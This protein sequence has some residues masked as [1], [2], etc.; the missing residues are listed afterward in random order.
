MTESQF[1]EPKDIQSISIEEAI[2]S[3][4]NNQ[5]LLPELQRKFVWN[6]TQV[7]KLFDSILRGYPMNTFM[8]WEITN[9]KIKDDAKFYKF[10]HH[11][12]KGIDE[13]NE[14]QPTGAFLDHFGAVIDGQQRLTALYIGLCGTYAYKSERAENPDE[15]LPK[16]SL[17]LDL[18]PP[19]AQ[20]KDDEDESEQSE[21]AQNDRV[22]YENDK[23]IFNFRFL[24]ADEISSGRIKG[25][26]FPVSSLLKSEFD[27]DNEQT[28]CEQLQKIGLIDETNEK[29]AVETIQKLWRRVRGEKLI[30]YYLLETQD[31]NDVLG[32]FVRTN[33]GGTRLQGA[34][35]LMSFTSAYWTAG[36]REKIEALT[37]EIRRSTGFKIDRSFILKTCLAVSGFPL[38][39][40]ASN[41]T[42]DKVRTFEKNWDDTEKSVKSGFKLIKNLGF[43]DDTFANKNIAIPIIYHIH[44]RNIADK[45]LK[46]GYYFWEELRE[47]SK[48]IALTYLKRVLSGN[49]ADPNLRRMCEIIETGNETKFPASR[50]MAVV[51]GSTRK[52]NYTIDKNFIEELLYR[53]DGADAYCV[54]QFIYDVDFTE[55]IEQDHMHPKTIFYNG[56]KT[57]PTTLVK[58][59]VPEVD[60]EYALENRHWNSV[61]NL[62]LLKQST[63]RMKLATPLTEWAAAHPNKELF[64]ENG[65][66]LEFKDFKAFIESRKR[67]LT[68]KL[69]EAFGV[70]E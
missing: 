57:R 58:M 59:G 51:Y 42:A 27:T 36:S 50:L 9:P 70:T 43:C 16:R 5:F 30:N 34:D 2:K 3:I 10:I 35:L 52:V 56:T 44:K 21:T 67:V 48:W 62:Q 14:N 68:A 1:N 28:I 69:M 31:L 60:V 32:I 63:N 41:I 33:S 13:I 20:I 11:Y 23:K 66:S 17:Y 4:S 65:T 47:I 45:V 26:W 12:Q 19:A 24:T 64:V 7:E 40:N 39:V 38:S 22:Q 25:R 54:L 37:Q 55:N 8:F 18:T 6:H 53:E 29:Y 61:L 49:S 15:Q 46:D